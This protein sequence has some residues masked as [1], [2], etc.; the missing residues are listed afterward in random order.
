MGMAKKGSQKTLPVSSKTLPVATLSNLCADSPTSSP[1]ASPQRPE[2]PAVQ[3]RS[4]LLT[5]AASFGRLRRPGSAAGSTAPAPEVVP[6]ALLLDRLQSSGGST[7]ERLRGVQELSAQLGL[8]RGRGDA[9]A[10]V[11]AYAACEQ[12]KLLMWL[13]QPLAEGDA[14]ERESPLLQASLGCL[15]QLAELGSAR[16]LL[17]ATGA[18]LLVRALGNAKAPGNLRAALSCAAKL[19]EEAE[20]GGDGVGPGCEH[21]APPASPGRRVGLGPRLCTRKGARCTSGVSGGGGTR[22]TWPAPR[23]AAAPAGLCS[24]PPNARPICAPQEEGCVHLLR[25]AQLEPALKPLA[26][27]HDAALR[28]PARQLVENGLHPVWR[29]RP[30]CL[31]G[32]WGGSGRSY[33]PQSAASAAWKLTMAS[34]ARLG[35]PQ[36]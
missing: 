5:R 6:V 11:E 10:G 18:A 16:A 4:S 36:S 15:A 1:S 7:K 21:R 23:A 17:D 22:A 25:A 26:Q 8:L 32:P 12:R 20:R 33:A 2:K 24:A 3:P 27:S 14:A 31:P 13:L 35:P 34:G 28:V 19:S 29:Q 9:S 30:I